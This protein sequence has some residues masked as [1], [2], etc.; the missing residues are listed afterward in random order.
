MSRLAQ[1]MQPHR[2][3]WRTRWGFVLAAAG[4]AVGLG[5]IWRFPYLCYENGGGAFLLVYF[6]ALATVGLPLL[7]LEYGIGH[8]MRGSAPLT[9]AKISPHWEWLGWWMGVFVMF[10]IVLYYAVI[11]AWCACYLWFS[12]TQ[13]WGTDTNAFFFHTFLGSTAGPKVIGDIR[14]PI[15]LALLLVWLANWAIV[16]FGVEKGI[17]RANKVFLPLLFVLMLGLIAW[18][19]TLP[20]AREGVWAYLRP[21][22]GRLASPKA[23]IDAYSQVLFSLSLGFG[24]MVTYASYLPREA[25]ITGNALAT[26]LI[27]TAVAVCAGV[28]VFGTLGYMA[29]QTGQP[30]DQVV[31]NGIGLAFVTYPK[32]I[33]LLPH[34][35][36]LFG[37][38]FFL[39]LL[40][41]G[42][43]SSISIV[44][45]F[46]A[47]VMDKFH[48][49]RRRVVTLLCAAGFLGGI[50]FAT[51]GGI[52]WVDIVDHFLGHYGLFLACILQCLLVA[53]VYG[54]HRLREHVNATSPWRV[55]RFLD[56]CLRYITPGVLLILV[57]NDLVQD[58]RAPYG[59]YS[60]LSIILIGRDWLLGTLVI[61]LFIAV[62]PWRRRL[63]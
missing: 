52:A 49:P 44:E 12:F 38:G 25:D 46:T 22:L 51:G 1:V 56:V 43:T 13:A 30:L 29:A 15:L 53:W 14:S 7:I 28:A 18:S 41:A 23:W 3:Q 6:I 9:F 17:E 27:D 10:G 34:L 47:A 50:V 21:D 62:R 39:A 5:N 19:L 20:G 57:G 2:P 16:F 33:S 31:T 59:G 48:Y 58:I 8:Q 63:E 45:A 11:I 4:S 37:V 24:I 36:E 42:I 26:G 60:W 54:A 61:A 40:M 32:A 35:R 55:N